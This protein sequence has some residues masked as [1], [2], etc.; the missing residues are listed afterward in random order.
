MRNLEKRVSELE[1]SRVDGR[2]EVLVDRCAMT[3][4]ELV[5]FDEAARRYREV[6]PR[7][8][9]DHELR[10]IFNAPRVDA[11]PLVAVQ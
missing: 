1:M 7:K 2:A 11:M 6:G 3:D 5:A 4:A 10:A 9:Q 8:M